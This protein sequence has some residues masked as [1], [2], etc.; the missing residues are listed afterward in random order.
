M[1]EKSSTFN[2]PIAQI[3]AELEAATPGPWSWMGGNPE[4][5]E[6]E[7]LEGPTARVLGSEVA[8]AFHTCLSEAD[9][10]LIANAPTYLSALLD[11]AE[12]AQRVGQTHGTRCG[13]DREV[14]EALAR[15]NELL[16]QFQ[17]DE[18]DK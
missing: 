12:A 18:S 6:Y 4:Y 13:C 2:Q 5:D 10:T 16:P 3:R 9:A 14:R 7:A 11:V 8:H 17:A 1:T 15:L